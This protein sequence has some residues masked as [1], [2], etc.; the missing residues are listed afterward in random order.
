VWE[1]GSFH[2][3]PERDLQTWL[4]TFRQPG[5]YVYLNH[6]L[7]EAVELGALAHFKVEGQWNDDLMKQ[8]SSP[9]PIVAVE[10]P[11]EKSR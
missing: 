2:N 5:I 11:G 10:G 8:M 3:P 6:M 9:Q 4:Y 7:V 1:T